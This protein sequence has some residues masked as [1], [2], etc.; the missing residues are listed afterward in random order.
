[1]LFPNGYRDSILYLLQDA[2]PKI[3]MGSNTDNVVEC[4]ALEDAEKSSQPDVADSNSN[5]SDICDDYCEED[6]DEY[7]YDEDIIDN[8]CSYGLAAKFDDLDLPPGVEATVPWLQKTAPERP[9]SDKDIVLEGDI[10]VKLNSFKQ[11]DT[12]EDYSDHFYAKDIKDLKKVYLSIHLS[13]SII[14][15]CLLYTNFI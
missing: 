13:S 1:M 12:V 9:R 10:D 14:S 2:F 11:F 5:L 3:L 15:F 7:E 6:D 8:D 4:D